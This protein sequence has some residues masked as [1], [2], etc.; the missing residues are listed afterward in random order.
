[1]VFVGETGQLLNKGIFWV[2]E[3]RVCIEIVFLDNAFEEPVSDYLSVFLFVRIDFLLVSAICAQHADTARDSEMVQNLVVAGL[4]D[5]NF[6]DLSA[7]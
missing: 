3:E 1:M 7:V 2:D 6:F 4:Y 5:F